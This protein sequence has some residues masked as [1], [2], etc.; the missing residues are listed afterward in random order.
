MASLDLNDV[1]SGTGHADSTASTELAATSGMC[2][3][4]AM[5]GPR[6]LGESRGDLCSLGDRRPFQDLADTRRGL[7]TGH[8]LHGLVKPVEEPALDLVSEPAAI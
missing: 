7:A 2:S 3:N 8:S 1:F 5:S 6:D 4:R